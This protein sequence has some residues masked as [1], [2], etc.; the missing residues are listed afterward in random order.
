MNNQQ[1]SNTCKHPGPKK[2]KNA[3]FQCKFCEQNWS[4]GQK[5]K[6]IIMSA[7]SG[8]TFSKAK[9]LCS[10]SQLQKAPACEKCFSNHIP[11]WLSGLGSSF[12]PH[13]PWV[14]WGEKREARKRG[15]ALR[16]FF[17]AVHSHNADTMP[18]TVKKSSNRDQGA[19]CPDTTYKRS[20]ARAPEA[21]SLQHKSPVK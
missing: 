17:P 15:H 1:V 21:P 5:R 10:N 3:S 8:R 2:K 18:H 12:S 19:S 14:Q 7:S 13:F 11:Q 16:D 20:P 4:S 6:Q 9:K